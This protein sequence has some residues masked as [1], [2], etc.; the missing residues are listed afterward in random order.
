M[1]TVKLLA[2]INYEDQLGADWLT[3]RGF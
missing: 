3:T 1:Q 2:K